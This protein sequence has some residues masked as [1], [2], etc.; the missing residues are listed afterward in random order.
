MNHTTAG[1]TKLPVIARELVRAGARIFHEDAEKGSF[2]VHCHLFWFSYTDPKANCFFVCKIT[3]AA[4]DY[5]A[6]FNNAQ[7]IECLISCGDNVD[8]QDSEGSTPLMTAVYYNTREAVDMLLRHGGSWKI[9][10]HKG[11]A[12][13][14]YIALYATAEMMQLFIDFAEA[15]VLGTVCTAQQT[16]E[17]LMPF[18]I[19]TRRLARS[20]ELE[21]L[22]KRL[23]EAM[24][25]SADG[26]A[27]GVSESEDESG[28][29]EFYDAL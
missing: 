14:H 5:A 20:P 25:A 8:H 16:H 28:N 13:L 24:S 12:V 6:A 23:L 27:V 18:Q 4:I 2:S 29:D 17:G 22:F 7:L 21:R 3:G 1:D 10:D 9:A 26:V 15:G 19:F 11:L